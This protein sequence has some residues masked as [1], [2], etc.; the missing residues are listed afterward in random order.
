MDAKLQHHFAQ[1]Q[2][3]AIIAYNYT[4]L[5]QFGAVDVLLGLP[6]VLS[7]AVALPFEEVFVPA[8]PRPLIDDL[9][10][11]VLLIGHRD[12]VNRYDSLNLSDFVVEVDRAGFS[13]D[14]D[15]PIWCVVCCGGG[16]VA[17]AASDV[18]LLLSSSFEF[19]QPILPKRLDCLEGHCHE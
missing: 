17:S 1:A 2:G 9:L 7:R 10:D 14:S 8:V 4:Y 13:G 3:V 5:Q 15:L 16:G 18:I 12:F 6:G 19:V 11:D